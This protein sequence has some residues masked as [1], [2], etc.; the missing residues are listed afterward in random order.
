[1]AQWKPKASKEVHKYPKS[2]QKSIPIKAVHPHG[3]F[4]HNGE[5]TMSGT[6]TDVNYQAASMEDQEFVFG[7][8]QELIKA[9]EIDEHA[10]LT[11]INWPIHADALQDDLFIPPKNEDLDEYSRELNHIYE[12]WA[13]EGTNSIRQQRYFTVNTRRRKIEDAKVWFN[14]ME[15]TLKGAFSKMG[16]DYERLDTRER[17]R[18]FHD[19]FR[20]GEESHFN[21]DVDLSKRRGH[22]VKDYIAPDGMEFQS[23]HFRIGKRYG[24]VLVLKEYPAYLRDTLLSE[25]MMLPKQMVLSVDYISKSKEDSLQRVQ[26]KLLSVDTEIANS[27]K[28]A[29]QQGNYNATVPL[30]LDEKRRG[31]TDIVRLI[32]EYDQRIVFAQITLLHMADTMEELNHDTESLVSI[33]QRHMCQFSTF[34]NQQ[35]AGLN[36]CLPYGLR[37]VN[38]LR[39]LTTENAATFIPFVTKDLWDRGGMCIGVN[40]ISKNLV[41]LDKKQAASQNAFVCG[42]TGSGKSMYIKHEII[43]TYL[44]TDDDILI[45]DPE[46]EQKP[47][48]DMLHGTFVHLS[49]GSQHHINAMDTMQHCEAGD[50]PVS[51]KCEF[52]LTF[53]E[54][55]IGKLN[56]GAVQQT[57][58]DRCARRLLTK[59]DREQQTVTLED[60]YL[61]LLDQPEPEARELAT[62]IEL[63]VSGSLNAFS[64]PTNVDM[65]N[66]LICYDIRDL[67]DKS[68]EL[69]MLII[70]DAI[71][72]R[73]AYNRSRGKR[74]W[75]FV[76]EFWL[77]FREEFTA[78]FFDSF[79]R[80]I[81]KYGALGTGVTQNV[82]SV[83]DS[84]IGRDMLGNS[85][86][87]FLFN[88]ST[89][90]RKRLA[91][92]L[93]ISDAQ[94][95][96]ITNA[97]SGTGLL[98]RSSVII[99]FDGRIDTNTK[100]YRAMTT[101]IEEV[102]V[103]Y[104]G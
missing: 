18:L 33:G 30:R 101:K 59:A 19:F 27:T 73:V 64:K 7:G 100:L 94:L 4:E 25:L 62:G 1:M 14:R 34:R 91:D 44:S 69:G 72:N 2:V 78:K 104:V 80:R 102:E 48:I 39:T 89:P 36:T 12:K 13:T 45:V 103:T 37:Y 17:L 31:L 99:P 86:H 92:L 60:L 8:Q 50:D 67:G 56:M 82:S 75:V 81:R 90:D 22:S 61:L 46:R 66:R 52:V 74:T 5:Y 88:Q 96:Y 3:I 28:N 23:G 43:H 29:N 11:V 49:A 20:H 15:S 70:L 16:S 10:K 47:I 42:I 85:E 77:M 54:K 93:D 32:K 51:I 97:E 83:L 41:I 71:Q 40:P 6:F 68:K 55:A 76:D 9:L 21:L 24:R 65:D 35:E 58:V 79:W 87:L 95:S 26:A 38:A 98:R 84:P 57:I 53:F 63:Y